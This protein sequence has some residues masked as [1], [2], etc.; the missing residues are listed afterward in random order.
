[1][2]TQISITPPSQ[3]TRQLNSEHL[4]RYFI[5]ISQ[6]IFSLLTRIGSHFSG[7]GTKAAVGPQGDLSLQENGIPTG[8]L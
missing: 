6:K 2:V 5:F 1:M 8:P 3:R 7:C 4:F